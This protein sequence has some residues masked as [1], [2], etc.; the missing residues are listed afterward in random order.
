[1]TLQKLIACS[2]FTL[3]SPMKNRFRARFNRGYPAKI[4]L[5]FNGSSGA[6]T[7]LL[8]LL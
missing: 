3:Y 1:M 7:L 5:P 6:E 4:A 2:R 8:N